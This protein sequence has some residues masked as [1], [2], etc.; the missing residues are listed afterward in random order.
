M[1]TNHRLHSMFATV[2]VCLSSMQRQQLLAADCLR[3]R[4][5][6]TRKDAREK[7]DENRYTNKRTCRS[8]EHTGYYIAVPAV[9]PCLDAPAE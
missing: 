1:I 8:H 6:V 2:I 3:V 5:K 9:G 7:E 4:G